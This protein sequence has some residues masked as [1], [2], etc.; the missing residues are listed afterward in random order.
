MEAGVPG[1]QKEWALERATVEDVRKR[2]RMWEQGHWM[3]MP[4]EREL[5]V[6]QS[7]LAWWVAMRI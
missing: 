3:Q 2:P 4:L 6:M 7:E 1:L 5:V